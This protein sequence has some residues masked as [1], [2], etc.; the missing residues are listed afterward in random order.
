M[1]VLFLYSELAGYFI[2]CLEALSK[3]GAE[4]H[5]VHWPVNKE[6]PFLFS[7]PKNIKHYERKNLHEKQ[8]IELAE[9]ISPDVIY[10]SGWV[11][12]EYLK[13]CKKFRGNI[14]VIVG[15]DN[16][17]KGTLKQ[18]AASLLSKTL[19]HDSFSH[20]W[21]PGNPQMSYAK[22]L[23]FSTTNILTG[24]YSCDHDFFHAL[25]LKYREA[26][27]K[28]F[29][30]RLIFTGRY[31]DFKGITDLWTAFIELD[32]E[33]AND[34]ELWCLGTGDIKPVIHPKIKHFGFIQPD[35][36]EKYISETGVFVLPSRLEPWGVAVHEFAAAG[37]PLVCSNEV[38][39]ADQ[40]LIEGENGFLFKNGNIQDLK[41]SLKKIM[42][43]SDAQL[44]KMGERSSEL[45]GQITPDTWSDTLMSVINKI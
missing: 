32:K 18:K 40:F 5:V 12:K 21:V 17:W 9:M 24:F 20:C 42:S 29:P 13:V 44:F 45:S 19:L 15:V 35:R 38:G 36:I 34:W 10:C 16:K 3:K 8:L 11:D 7:F 33:H 31:Y 25:F 4:I 6:A 39:A 26:K 14:P 23:K 27:K 41:K 30:R 43:L 37:F 1:K 28:K 2:S 22:R